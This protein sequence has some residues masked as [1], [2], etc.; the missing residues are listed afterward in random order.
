MPTVEELGS[1]VKQKYPGTYDDMSDLE[2]GQRV[3]Q[4][5]PGSYDDFVDSRPQAAVVQERRQQLMGEAFRFMQKPLERYGGGEGEGA[6]PAIGEL[7]GNALGAATGPLA[8]VA[9]PALGAAGAGAGRALELAVQGK[10]VTAKE[11]GVEAGVSLLPEAAES[12]VRGAGRALL[13]STPGGKL[14]RFD[15]AARRA[16]GLGETVFQPP[17]RAV[18]EK[19]FAMVRASGLKVDV[20]DIGQHVTA[21]PAGKYDELASEVAGIDRRLKT[22]GRFTQLLEGVRKGMHGGYDIGEL[23]TLR[24]ELRKRRDQLEPPEARQLLQDLQDAVD[25][26]IDTGLARGRVAR[27]QTPELLQEAR[28]NYARLRASEDMAQ[29][30]ENTI[31]STPDL[32]MASFNMRQFYDNLRKGNTKLAEQINRSLDQTPGARARFDKELDDI[33]GLFKTIEMPLTDVGGFRRSAIIGGIG[34]MLSTI[35]LTDTGR[36][37]F[38][39]A[40]VQGRGQV[41]LNALAVITNAVDRELGI[42][43]ADPEAPAQP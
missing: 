21:L 38:R 10:P 9:I 26:A 12:A 37:L 24:S 22:G 3:K 14:I 35:M 39:E 19:Q 36:R 41:S 1:R 31:T 6:L 7:A 29:M 16:R 27:G 18:V 17:E 8:P 25:D 20:G 32:A 28:R 11:V 2:V 5:Y 43:R 4:K 42:V 13:R 40:V 30:V 33:S 34:Q 15:E 23:Q